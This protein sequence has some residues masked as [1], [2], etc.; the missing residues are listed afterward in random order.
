M[1]VQIF[2][3]AEHTAD[4]G[5]GVAG[6]LTQPP[7]VEET[8]PL[9]LAEGPPL[10]EATGLLVLAEGPPLVASVGTA[11]AAL[12]CFG[13]PLTELP[14]LLPAFRSCSDV[15]PGSFDSVEPAQATAREATAARAKPTSKFFMA[16]ILWLMNRVSL[17]SAADV[18]AVTPRDRT[19]APHSTPHASCSQC[20]SQSC[21]RTISGAIR[22]CGVELVGV[23]SR[24]RRL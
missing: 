13:A 23:R 11:L 14:A 9:V 2:C 21:A 24:L 8:P 7:L 3:L 1:T 22:G 17:L 6:G 19:R 4:D 15:V 20:R 5:P 10:V 16:G 12:G 18:P